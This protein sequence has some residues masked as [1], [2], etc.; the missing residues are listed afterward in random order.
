M[1]PEDTMAAGGSQLNRPE[2]LGPRPVAPVSMRLLVL[3]MKRS[4]MTEIGPGTTTPCQPAGS[5]ARM[6]PIQTG[7]LVSVRIQSTIERSVR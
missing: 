5:N 4:H 1:I 2:A 7:F 6:D 3:A